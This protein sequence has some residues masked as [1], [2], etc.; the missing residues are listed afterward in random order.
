MTVKT[1]LPEVPA[2]LAEVQLI[3]APTCAAAAGMSVSWFHDEVRA[4]RAPKPVIQ[5]PRCTRWQ[6][7]TVRG[8][9]I[10]RTAAASAT[11]GAEALTARARKASAAAQAK[12]RTQTAQQGA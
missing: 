7:A 1:D 12:R 3:D 11:E 2:A 6:V 10:E 9:L 4:G 5:Q 8:W